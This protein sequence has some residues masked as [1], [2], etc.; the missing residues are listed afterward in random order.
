LS[1]RARYRDSGLLGA[2]FAAVW[3]AVVLVVRFVALVVRGGVLAVEVLVGVLDWVGA[4][5]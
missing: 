3:L 4:E 1:L 2:V 5:Y